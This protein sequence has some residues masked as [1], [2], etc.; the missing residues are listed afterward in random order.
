MIQSDA[1]VIGYHQTVVTTSV[2]RNKLQL[3]RSEKLAKRPWL[4]HAFSTR[5]GGVSRAYGGSAFNLGFTKQDS[6]AAVERNLSGGVLQLDLLDSRTN[7]W[8]QAQQ[9]GAK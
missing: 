3:L 4:V 2:A 8:I 5:V 9:H 7:S 6:R 1:S